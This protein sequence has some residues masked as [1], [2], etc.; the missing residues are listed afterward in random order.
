MSLNDFDTW[1]DITV[2]WWST[3]TLYIW[4]LGCEHNVNYKPSSSYNVFEQ[5]HLVSWSVYIANS[6]V[7]YES[8][9]VVQ[10]DWIWKSPKIWSIQ[11]KKGTGIVFPQTETS[12]PTFSVFVCLTAWIL[13]SSSLSHHHSFLFTG[14]QQ[15]KH[16]TLVFL[17]FILELHVPRNHR[18]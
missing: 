9:H 18:I 15:Y 1:V 3:K 5:I 12:F 13:G 7:F 6:S 17:V 2:V 16:F 14:C 4:F 10:D 8:Y 11:P